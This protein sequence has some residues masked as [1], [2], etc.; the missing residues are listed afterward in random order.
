MGGKS[1]VLFKNFIIKENI[2]VLSELTTSTNGWTG[3]G[4]GFFIDSSGI[5]ATNYH[6]I[7]DAK[8]IE[9]CFLTHGIKNTYKATVV[10]TDRTNDLAI[11]KIEDSN[12]KHLKRIPYKFKNEVSD[13]GSSVFAL[14]Y[15]MALSL[16]GEEIKFTDGKISARSGFQGEINTYQISVPI[17]PGNSGGP[18]FDSKGN[19]IGI[20]NSKLTNGENVSYA[21]KS[22]YLNTLAETSSYQIKQPSEKA[23]ASKSLVEKI[24]TVSDYV[25]LIK[26]R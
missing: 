19:I 25:V 13:V 16:M 9:V 17:Q 20:V 4:S 11:L 24:K 26:T 12:F 2:N 21:I 8:Q 5:I 3:N 6:V 15:P 18:L 22:A 10:S 14:G 7:Q 1:E 23:I